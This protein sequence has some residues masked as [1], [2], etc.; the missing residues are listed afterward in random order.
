MGKAAPSR[1]KFCQ[2][3]ADAMRKTLNNQSQNLPGNISQIPAIDWMLLL[4][5]FAEALIL[6]HFFQLHLTS[7]RPIGAGKQDELIATMLGDKP[8]RDHLRETLFL[9][10]AKDPVTM[11]KALQP[12]L[13]SADLQLYFGPCLEDLFFH[14]CLWKLN[15][16]VDIPADVEAPEVVDI[17]K[18]AVVKFTSTLDHKGRLRSRQRASDP[19]GI[20][21]R[22]SYKPPLPPI[23]PTKL[24]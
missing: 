6:P 8:Y 24:Y 2:L 4:I 12:G 22:P 14:T 20:T 3:L 11:G 21:W 17:P 10:A 5:S 23:T 16:E 15:W 19:G 18:A 13:L 9:H 7:P 1:Q